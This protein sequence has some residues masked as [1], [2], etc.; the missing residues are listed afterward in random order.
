MDEPT[1]MAT[2]YTATVFLH[3]RTSSLF[4][5]CHSHLPSFDILPGAL[6]RYQHRRCHPARRRCTAGAQ[7][8]DP[9]VDFPEA[10]AYAGGVALPFCAP[11]RSLAGRH[12]RAADAAWRAPSARA[13]THSLTSALRP[14]T[15]PHPSQSPRRVVAARR[16]SPRRGAG[17]AYFLATRARRRL[18]PQGGFGRRRQLDGLSSE[19]EDGSSRL[20][21]SSGRLEPGGL[22]VAVGKEDGR[23]G[24]GLA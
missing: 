14:R 21:G 10:G 24:V 15:A 7:A 22:G 5:R 11:R 2:T 6:F 13:A 18:I 19:R 20:G 8:S 1:S 23:A 9:P 3:P 12:R 16:R 17:G 4:Y